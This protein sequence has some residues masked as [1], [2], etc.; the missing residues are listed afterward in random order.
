MGL[1][2]F[3]NPGDE[4]C[5]ICN[6]EDWMS[7]SWSKHWWDY[8]QFLDPVFIQRQQQICVKPSTF[9]TKED[10]SQ[11]WCLLDDQGHFNS[12]LFLRVINALSLWSISLYLPKP[13][14][15]MSLNDSL[16]TSVW[17][18]VGIAQKF[19]TR[20]RRFKPSLDTP[21]AHMPLLT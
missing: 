8:F 21:G 14:L 1:L 20:L 19:S 12:Q 3:F 7:S 5:Q 16:L 18:P 9:W 13:Y 6:R 4:K 11:E 15:V 10:S 2:Q 17:Y